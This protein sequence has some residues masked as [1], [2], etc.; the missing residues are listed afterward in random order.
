MAAEHVHQIPTAHVTKDHEEGQHDHDHHTMSDFLEKKEE[1]K[2]TDELSVNEF[3]KDHV[4]KSEEMKEEEKHNPTVAD[5]N[6]DRSTNIDSSGDVT[7][8]EKTEEKKTFMET[9]KEKLP[10]GNK[11]TTDEEVAPVEHHH[12]TDTNIHQ[13]DYVEEKKGFMEKIKEKLPGHHKNVEEEKGA[14]Y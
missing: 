12:P 7:K 1:Q 5:H 4:L 6:L 9:I 13:G 14:N 10:G 8:P 11:K 2:P 3:V